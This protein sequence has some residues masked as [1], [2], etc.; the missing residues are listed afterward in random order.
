MLILA[1]AISR[2]LNLKNPLVPGLLQWQT[3]AN[4]TIYNRPASLRS[5][6]MISPEIS[7]D[8]ER[9]LDILSRGLRLDI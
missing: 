1:L 9:E 3:E 4:R 5:S 6:R 2:I 7:R 8:F